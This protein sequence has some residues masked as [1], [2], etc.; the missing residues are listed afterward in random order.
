MAHL[1]R[2]HILFNDDTF[3][4]IWRCHNKNWLLKPND[5][6]SLYYNLLL[7]Y[8]EEYG[9]KVY[10]YCFMTNHIHM[11]GKCKTVEGISGLMRTVNSVFSKRI[12]K[13][14]GRC[15]QVIMDRFKSP[16]IQT[17]QDLLNVMRYIDLNPCRAKMVNHPK[18]YK[19]SSFAYYAY[20]KNDPLITPAPSYLAISETISIRMALYTEIVEDLWLERNKSTDKNSYSRTLFI[21]NPD[22]VI[23][24]Y[25]YIKSLKKIKR[26]VSFEKLR[27]EYNG[28]NKFLSSV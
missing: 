8:K 4:L 14:L 6:K 17:D 11:T 13:K 7:K 21:G 12:N 18:Y 19:W 26:E 10:S 1:S 15:G 24:R 20:G 5:A 28:E 27:C 25:C 3:H 9:V 2:K 22:W 16:V 23:T